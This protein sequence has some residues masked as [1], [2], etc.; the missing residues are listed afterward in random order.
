MT[1]EASNQ[2]AG[3]TPVDAAANAPRDGGAGPAG[4]VAGDSSSPSMTLMTAGTPRV[5][6]WIA[7][8]LGVLAVVS[9]LANQHRQ[10]VARDEVVYMAAGERYAQWWLDLATGEPETATRQRI[11][12]V[13]GGAFGGYGNPEHPP[14]WKT[15]FGLSERVVHRG[16]GWTGRVTA[17]RLPAA[18][19]FG[20]WVWLVAAFAA[21][22]WGIA[23]GAVSGAALWLMP[24]V[25]FH[26]G[27]AAFDVPVAMMW[28][29]CVYCYAR[30]LERARWGLALGV[31][32]GLLL[33]TK[34]NAVVLPS[35]FALHYLSLTGYRAWAQLS[36]APSAGAVGF[37]RRWWNELVGLRPSL[38]PALALLGPLVLLAL[39]PRLWFDP[40]DHARGWIEFHLRH[41]HYNYEYLG[42]NWNAPPFPWH[43]PLVTTA[44]V[45]P[46]ATLAAAVVGAGRLAMGRVGRT[47][48]VRPGVGLERRAFTMPGLL[49]FLSAGAA[50]GPFVLRTTPIFGAEKHW[51]AAFA[52]IAIY[53][54]IGLLW[55]G[56]A[57]ARAWWPNARRSRR[58][59]M[60]LAVA[61]PL[62]AAAVETLRAQPYALTHYNALA[63]G[64]PGGADLGMNRQFWGYAA[65]GV[66][67]WL[68]ARA[69]D[70]EGGPA[71]VY[72]HDASPAWG[73]YRRESW[74]DASFVDS[75]HEQAGVASSDFAIVIH[76]RHFNR[77][78]IM[79]WRDYGTVAPAFVLTHRGVPIVSVYRRPK[80]PGSTPR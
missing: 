47:S 77:H 60:A 23:V 4:T 26:A 62:F 9:V 49:L 8:F 24:R 74:L 55:A 79:I 43:V 61:L 50:M 31:C 2:T 69:G 37:A 70:V 41:V 1:A 12:A 58:A 65:R 20:L 25:L 56:R 30:A 51:I 72:T 53:A 5:H 67:P 32:F 19:A 6:R 78:D 59:A 17:H 66:L 46:V 35:V 73:I 28:F 80:A 42:R 71:R 68:N 63:G 13:F 29:A 40:V 38:F 21:R 16:L 39:W 52:T 34:H 36:T 64:A 76:E 54:G 27:F 3:D 10:G 45:V 15:L 48:A 33:A 18:V 57:L 44:L 22:Y 14:L 11:D 75:G 7:P